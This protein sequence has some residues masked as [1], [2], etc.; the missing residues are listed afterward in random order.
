MWEGKINSR[1]L[2]MGH[3]ILPL[4]GCKARETVVAKYELVL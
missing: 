1:C 2:S 4:C 3:R